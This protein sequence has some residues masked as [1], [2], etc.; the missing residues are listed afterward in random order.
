MLGSRLLVVLLV[1]AFNFR[2][3][4]MEEGNVWEK[5][6]EKEREGKGR[7]QAANAWE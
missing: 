4:R 5:G 2:L 7:E 6:R 3:R 1:G